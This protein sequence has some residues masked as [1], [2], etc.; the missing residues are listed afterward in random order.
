MKAITKR[1]ANIFACLADVLVAPAPPFP[2]IG[3]TT[4]T[5]AW[6]DWLAHAPR[7]NRAAL[8]ATLYAFEVAPVLLGFRHRLRT[9]PAERRR[10]AIKRLERLAGPAAEII[11]SS[12]ALSYYGDP[13]VA[14]LLGYDPR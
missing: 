4:A 12:A 6:D 14:R 13:A 8:R 9:L 2:P 7:P 5:A 3:A 11:R 10:A 1:E